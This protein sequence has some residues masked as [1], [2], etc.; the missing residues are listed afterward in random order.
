[1]KGWNEEGRYVTYMPQGSEGMMKTA[2]IG[3]KYTKRGKIFYEISFLNGRDVKM[4]AEPFIRPSTPPVSFPQ[5]PIPTSDLKLVVCDG[6]L[7][8]GCLSNARENFPPWTTTKAELMR[9]V[10]EL[11]IL[12]EVK[13]RTVEF[14]IPNEDTESFFNCNNRVISASTK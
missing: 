6:Y 5:S 8:G 1:M 11:K 2:V 14:N 7:Y 4:V 9:L 3:K 10:T 12:R 13:K